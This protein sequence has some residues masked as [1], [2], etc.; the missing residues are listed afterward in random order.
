MMLIYTQTLLITILW[1][2]LSRLRH[3]HLS[4]IIISS[5]FH[6]DVTLLLLIY[7]ST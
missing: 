5:D 1:I 2:Y 4:A 3:F 6:I 7:Y